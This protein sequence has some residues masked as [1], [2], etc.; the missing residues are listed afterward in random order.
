MTQKQPATCEDGLQF[1]L[2]NVRIVK[3]T[4]ADQATIGIDEFTRRRPWFISLKP[5]FSLTTQA[6]A[7]YSLFDRMIGAITL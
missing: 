7:I 2:V 4:P 6:K 1:L 3:D 5:I